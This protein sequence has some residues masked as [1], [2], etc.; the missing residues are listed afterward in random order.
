MLK[1]A[2]PGC[3]HC[4]PAQ[5][6]D[7]RISSLVYRREDHTEIVCV[8]CVL[9]FEKYVYSS[10]NTNAVSKIDATVVSQYFWQYS[11]VQFNLVTSVKPSVQMLCS[12]NEV[13]IYVNILN[14]FQMSS[15]NQ[16]FAYIWLFYYLTIML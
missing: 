2:D 7:C 13:R 12:Q 10:D 16:L 15:V 11:L 5:L 3:R 8:I 9:L 14:S 6:R 4:S 1:L